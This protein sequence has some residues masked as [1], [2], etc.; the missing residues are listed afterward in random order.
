[1][2]HC[3][4]PPCIHRFIDFPLFSEIIIR[5]FYVC[6]LIEW[7]RHFFFNIF[8]GFY[9]EIVSFDIM[10]S[11]KPVLVNILESVMKD[12]HDINA[13]CLIFACVI[14]LYL[15]KIIHCEYIRESPVD[16]I[17]YKI[18]ENMNVIVFCCFKMT[19]KIILEK[20]SILGFKTFKNLKYSC[21][22]FIIIHIFHKPHDIQIRSF[23]R[24]YWFIEEFSFKGKMTM[25][26]IF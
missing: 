4:L 7:H 9:K 24:I 11:G 25:N 8:L 16:N 1:M 3:M 21:I 13:F 2:L 17:D 19:V 14:I 22:C 12:I 10:F 5:K 18:F 6:I 15:Y 20:F 26:I 23:V